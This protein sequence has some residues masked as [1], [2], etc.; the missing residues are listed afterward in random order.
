MTAGL[1]ANWAPGRRSFL[2]RRVFKSKTQTTSMSV[3][4]SLLPSTQPEL[5]D[6][7]DLERP[8][9]PAR[10]QFASAW[11]PP[12]ESADRSRLGSHAEHGQ[13]HQP[14]DAVPAVNAT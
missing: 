4:R 1:L 10:P 12:F 8:T 14:A 9:E 11:P 13:I 5:A 6:V 2:P 3:T 7:Q